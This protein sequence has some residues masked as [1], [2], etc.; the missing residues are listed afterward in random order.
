M[1]VRPKEGD[2]RQDAAKVDHVVDENASPSDVP[3]DTSLK[4]ATEV[5]QTV[6]VRGPAIWFGFGLLAL[7]G[8]ALILLVLQLLYGGAGT[9]VQPGTPTVEPQAVPKV[10][11]TPAPDAP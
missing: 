9:E 7:A 11:T 6:G 1:M 8:V 3:D 2:R 4:I 10:T 5:E